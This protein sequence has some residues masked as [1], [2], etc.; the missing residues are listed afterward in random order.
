MLV[1]MAVVRILYR[2]GMENSSAMR[3]RER[4]VSR[5]QVGLA[6]DRILVARGGPCLGDLW[7]LCSTMTE[8]HP[9]CSCQRR[10]W[11]KHI[12]MEINGVS[13]GWHLP[14]T[15]VDLSWET[16]CMR[17]RVGGPSEVGRRLLLRIASRA[18]VTHGRR[19]KSPRCA[20]YS[21]GQKFPSV[22]HGGTSC[23]LRDL[24]RAASRERPRISQVPRQQTERGGASSSR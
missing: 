14:L 18:R 4:G 10:V 16:I 3:R 23:G 6:V 22:S 12:V 19:E 11:S 17:Q 15:R 5:Q 24:T 20:S 9:H 1:V 13:G 21:I 7:A 2:P 8:L